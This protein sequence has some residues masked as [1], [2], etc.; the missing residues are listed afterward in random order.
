MSGIQDVFEI[1]RGKYGGRRDFWYAA[2]DLVGNFIKENSLKHESSRL[3]LRASVANASSPE[4]RSAEISQLWP[5]HLAGGIRV[6]HLHYSGE[7]YLLND[8]QWGK[9]T[10]TVLTNVT[11][12]LQKAQKVGFD[13]LMDVADSA[14]T[15]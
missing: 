10:K 14:H 4:L 12:K 8:A 6:P 15:M 7:L 11:E 2:I 3:P 1:L 13:Q 5:G 9:F